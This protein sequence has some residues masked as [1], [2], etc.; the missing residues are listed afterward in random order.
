MN[1]PIRNL[2]QATLSERKAR[3]KQMQKEWYQRNKTRIRSKP[4]PVETEE[5]KERKR[6][7]A[8][9]RYYAKREEILVQ[10]AN[11]REAIN[12]QKRAYYRTPKGYA[13][14]Q[15]QDARR[16]A[17]FKNAPGHWGVGQWRALV[18]FYCPDG[19][20]LACNEIEPLTADHVVPLALGGTNYISN[21]QPLCAF[22][23]NSKN[24]SEIDYR[25]DGGQY[26]AQL[27]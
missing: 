1:T 13:M 3:Q 25:P 17:R 10:M 18:A 16:R 20:C 21:M 6:R 15:V 27:Q 26:A 23:N 22:C 5:R 9:D 2:E 7:L 19:R 24:A 8:L 12:A 11:N 4:R 14:K